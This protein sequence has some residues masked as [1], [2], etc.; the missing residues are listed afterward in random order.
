MENVDRY[1]KI[2]LLSEKQKRDAIYLAIQELVKQHFGFSKLA[3]KRGKVQNLLGEKL[4]MPV[5]ARF[6]RTVTQALKALGIRAVCVHKTYLYRGLHDE[7][8][9]EA[10]RKH[11]EA[12]AERKRLRDLEKKADLSPPQTLP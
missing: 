12:K 2:K 9:L 4:N 1:V 6:K 3:V 8:A 10:D 7:A 5:N 11:Q